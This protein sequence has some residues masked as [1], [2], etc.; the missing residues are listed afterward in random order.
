MATI[1]ERKPR[2]AEAEETV[3][4]TVTQVEQV[5]GVF[6]RSYELAGFRAAGFYVG[7]DGR[8]DWDR[9]D[10]VQPPV[11]FA[12]RDTNTGWSTT[13]AFT[14]SGSQREAQ[15]QRTACCAATRIENEEA[16]SCPLSAMN[17]GA[18][19]DAC[20]I[21]LFY[22]PAGIAEILS[23]DAA[24]NAE[25]AAVRRVLQAS[26]IA[27]AAANRNAHALEPPTTDDVS[28]RDGTVVFV[29]DARG[30]VRRACVTKI[31]NAHEV[32]VGD[33]DI[34]V[35]LS[36][37]RI[38]PLTGLEDCLGC[39]SNTI[40]FARLAHSAADS[41]GDHC[42]AQQHHL[43]LQMDPPSATSEHTHCDAPGL[44]IVA[45]RG[46]QKSP[47][48]DRGDWLTNLNAGD[49]IAATHEGFSARADTIPL[50]PLLDHLRRGGSVL[51]T[52]HSLGSAVA[53]IV[54][55]RVIDE[56][57]AKGA[58]ATL[59]SALKERRVAFIGWA[60]PA[61]GT[62][63]YN[64]EKSGDAEHFFHISDVTDRVPHLPNLAVVWP[65]L[66]TSEAAS[67]P[68]FAQK[69]FAR[70][71]DMFKRQTA[72]VRPLEL[73]R[74]Y[75]FWRNRDHRVDM[76]LVPGT[77]SPVISQKWLAH[78]FSSD[79]TLH[80]LASYDSHLRIMKPLETPLWA[81]L[82]T[83]IT[84]PD[85]ITLR[86]NI[87]Y[88]S[89][90]RVLTLTLHGDSAML[91]ATHEVE[92]RITQTATGQQE[93]YPV[94]YVSS[95]AG[96]SAGHDVTTATFLAL[97]Y[98]SK[99]CVVTFHLKPRYAG[100]QQ[101]DMDHKWQDV[102]T[103]TVNRVVDMSVLSTL[104]QA[105]FLSVGADEPNAFT[106]QL[107]LRLVTLERLSSNLLALQPLENTT[108]AEEAQVMRRTLGDCRLL[109]SADPSAVYALVRVG[110]SSKSEQALRSTGAF[111]SGSFDLTTDGWTITP[112]ANDEEL[113]D[114]TPLTAG[115]LNLQGVKLSFAD[116]AYTI[117]RAGEVLDTTDSGW[118]RSVVKAGFEKKKD[119]KTTFLIYCVKEGGKPLPLRPLVPPCGGA[120]DVVAKCARV[121]VH[122]EAHNE[123]LAPAVFLRICTD[124]EAFL[125]DDLREEEKVPVHGA[126]KAA[127]RTRSWMAMK[128]SASWTCCVII[129]RCPRPCR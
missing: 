48:E 11:G 108:A 33:N 126:V 25:A 71:T 69:A 53:E 63:E 44:L 61:I 40:R 21:P 68:Q 32:Y 49:K 73:S 38:A 6:N 41:A 43:L 58:P 116:G 57:R 113:Y 83:A 95:V 97:Q 110:G 86:G 84:A 3:N 89:T 114:M 54:C 45:V 105:L 94:H 104:Q 8:T 66:W 5:K 31:N 16:P 75:H 35:L 59:A 13:T 26:W 125:R 99:G 111:S 115:A 119:S 37:V 24:E 120:D 106:K 92:L 90:Y 20:L 122:R 77:A 112:T 117:R 93:A 124:P 103:G 107:E 70:L 15:Q 85:T 17:E 7:A 91:L 30:R 34:P 28:V 81:P 102:L 78:G 4:V 47:L 23:G 79:S 56:C 19:R 22:R 101:L 12:W 96:A 129:T 82:A 55:Q 128:A 51:F 36:D 42:P 52:G 109:L 1:H 123:A 9:L 64:V 2:R 87:T 88:H 60:S 14:Y 76:H 72:P 65:E 46:C 80:T 39:S 127:W 98:P 67:A 10:D 50:L 27:A 121:I 100:Q 29:E 18:E 62:A 74:G 118:L